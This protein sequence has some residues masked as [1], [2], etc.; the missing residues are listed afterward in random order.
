MPDLTAGIRHIEGQRD[1]S[2]LE[3][4][5]G[6]PRLPETIAALETAEVVYAGELAAHGD[7]DRAIRAA[8]RA[9]CRH[10][11]GDGGDRNVAV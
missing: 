4:W 2:R 3:R 1:R 7:E 10:L 5:R 11:F 8:E 6:H 9:A